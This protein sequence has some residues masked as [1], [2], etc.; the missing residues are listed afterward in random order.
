MHAY[1]TCGDD[2]ARAYARRPPSS[3]VGARAMFLTEP[4]ALLLTGAG[5]LEEAAEQLGEWVETVMISLG[6]HGT[7]AMSNGRRVDVPEFD[8]GRAVDSTGSRDLLCAAYAWA[9]LR[10]A[11]LDERIAWAQLYS[12]LAM[13]VP[14][15]TRGALTEDRLV[16]EGLTRGL[17]RPAQP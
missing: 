1:L 7:V 2:D 13:T 15:A 14:T 4:H 6:S 3:L 9:D 8:T 12:Q 11:A 5:S 16:E 17:T 10:G